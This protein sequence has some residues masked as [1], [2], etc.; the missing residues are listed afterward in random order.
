MAS[1]ILT[2]TVEGGRPP[3][4]IRVRCFKNGKHLLDLSAPKSFSQEIG[5]LGKGQYSFFINGFNPAGGK[6]T[7]SLTEDEI[8]LMPPDPS[9]ITNTGIAYLVAFHFEVS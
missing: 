2:V 3:V 6:T 5:N 4:T 8:V 7:C 1:T 9:P